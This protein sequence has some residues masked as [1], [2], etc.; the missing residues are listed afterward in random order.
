MFTK[1]LVKI[2]LG[3]KDS[4]IKAVKI[5]NKIYLLEI[6]EYR[7]ASEIIESLQKKMLRSKNIQ[8]KHLDD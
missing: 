3:N 7:S 1:L 6:E 5:K 2:L 8:P 4:F